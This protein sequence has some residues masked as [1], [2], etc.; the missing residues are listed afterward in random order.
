[1]IDGS[2]IERIYDEMT[3]EDSFIEDEVYQKY[4]EGDEKIFNELKGLLGGKLYFEVED[5]IMSKSSNGERTGFIMGFKC[6][7][8]LLTE[9]GL[10]KAGT[11]A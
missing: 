2:I 10:T 3:T 5:L 4:I 1:M 11:T 6:A 8:H 9:C 7:M